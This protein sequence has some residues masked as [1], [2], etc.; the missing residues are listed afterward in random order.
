VGAHWQNS[1]AECFIGTIT[2]WARTILLHAMT[3]W[4]SVVTEE[5]WT[6]ALHHAVNFHNYSVHKQQTMMPYELFTGQTPS[7]SLSDFWVFGSPTYIL[8]K[9]L[10]D[11]S[12]H[13]KWKSRVWLGV[14][15]GVSNCH[16]SAIPLTAFVVKTLGTIIP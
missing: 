3:K 13:S 2:Q 1:I 14:Y 12:S 6:F 5:M 4:P 7:W 8:S 16:S 9:T 10:Q 15:I 11:G